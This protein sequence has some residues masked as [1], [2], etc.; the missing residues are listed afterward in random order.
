M[1][2]TSA[3]SPSSSA[4]PGSVE[5]RL[6]G[7]I[8]GRLREANRGFRRTHP[9]E[10]TDRQPVHTVY[11]GAHLFRAGSARRL[12]EIALRFL[13]EYAPDAESFAE[14]VGLAGDGGFRETVYARV[15]EKL[16]TEPVE[17][18]R[19]DFEDGYGNR[20]DEEE[21]GTAVE[22]ARQVARGLAEDSLPPFLGIRI[23]P[24]GE[25]L[26][27]RGVRTLDLFLTTLRAETRGRLPGNFVVTL[28]KVVI[29]EQVD[30]LADLFEALEERLDL[31]PGTLRLE[32]MVETPRSILDAGGRCPL[33]ELVEA[34]RGRCVAAHFGV[35]DYTASLSIT[36]QYQ[37]MGHLH[38]DM[39]RRIMQVALA[40][41]GVWLSDGATNVLPVP[42]HRAPK[43]GP[44]LTAEQEAENRE[45]VHRA[46]RLHCSDVRHSLESGLYQGWD[47]H[48]AQLATRYAAVYAFFLEGLEA[49]SDRL[50]SFVER[51]AQATLHG[52]VME[53]A[54]TGQGLL[55]FF[56]RGLSCG[57]IREEEALGTG[58]TLEELRGRSFPAILEARRATAPEPPSP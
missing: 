17:D 29:P 46:W 54:A 35:Y 34:G 56:L 19:I 28:P 20:P 1:A 43:E 45:S 15:R 13:E 48:P 22:A 2:Q 41:T 24:F 53:D 23:K 51:L 6:L 44:P 36:A 4:P 38:C 31:P 5:P 37:T 30:A 57:A 10:R 3:S 40:G 52:D 16:E 50:R 33:F 27:R 8:L 9:G 7:P 26:A 42:V 12:G 49:A 14:A 32:I 58:L 21:D 25:Q 18:F 39:A 47:L 55:N 11:G